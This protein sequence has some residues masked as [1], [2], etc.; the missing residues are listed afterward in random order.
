MLENKLSE[1]SI[2]V[3]NLRV[4]KNGIGYT[5]VKLKERLFT[6]RLNEFESINKSLRIVL[7]KLYS[8]FSVS[9]LHCGTIVIL[10]K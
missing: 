10:T 8:N 3:L 6:Q 4:K 7:R 2:F 9:T 5:T 1:F